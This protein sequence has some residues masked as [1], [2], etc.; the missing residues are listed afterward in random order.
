M[1]TNT[2]FTTWTIGGCLLLSSALV[3]ACNSEDPRYVQPD[4]A[5]EAGL[6]GADPDAPPATARRRE[7]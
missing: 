3:G 4:E 1:P 5:I 2:T 7:A 6:P